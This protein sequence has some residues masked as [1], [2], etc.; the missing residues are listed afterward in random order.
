[1]R[2]IGLLGGSFDPVHN[3]HLMLAEY[4]RKQLN[5]D[6]IHFIPCFQSAYKNKHIQ[7]S[8]IHRLRMLI[9]GIQNKV[10]KIDRFELRMG[11][12]SYTIETVKY[13]KQKYPNDYL[14]FIAGEDTINTFDSW[15]DS[16]EIKKLI[17]VKFST[18]DFYVPPIRFTSTLIRKLIKEDRSIKYLVPEAV[19]EYITKNKLYK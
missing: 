2:R 1:M 12:I 4:A 3:G 13:Y 16:K 19:E 15:K 10:D 14:C 11:I 8:D 17:D 5:L 18:K 7:A 9:L 6:T